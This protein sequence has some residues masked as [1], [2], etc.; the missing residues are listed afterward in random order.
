MN[1][2]RHFLNISFKCLV[3]HKQLDGSVCKI[4]SDVFSTGMF[5]TTTKYSHPSNPSYG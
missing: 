3:I 2:V 1:Q 5:W 4:Q